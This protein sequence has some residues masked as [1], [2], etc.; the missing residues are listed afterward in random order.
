[1]KTILWATLTANGN[2]AQSS[3]ENPAKPEAL[4]DFAAQ[5]K[6]TGNFIVGRK[7]FEGFAANGGGPFGD[8]DIVVISQN[9]KEIPG[10]KVVESPQEAL[11]YLQAK[12]HHTALLAGGADLHNAFLGQGLVDEVIFNIAPVLEGK[13]LNLLLNTDHYQYQDVQLLDFKS[14]GGGVVQLH[15]AIGHK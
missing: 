12:G 15:Y 14:L 1:M 10:V 9:I 4:A 6:T 11:T 8:L 13:G 7:T 5:A 2:Y 3:A